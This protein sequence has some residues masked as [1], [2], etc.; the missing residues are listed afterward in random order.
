MKIELPQG[1]TLSLDMPDGTRYKGAGGYAEVDNP[2]HLELVRNRSALRVMGTLYT[3][4]PAA[5]SVEC[6]SCH[7]QQYAAMADRPCPKCGT[8]FASLEVHVC[9]DCLV[10]RADFEGAGTHLEACPNCQS[11]AAP[12]PAPTKEDRND[13]N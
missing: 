9:P 10:E 7:F 5:S 8:A 6:P 3:P 1:N 2:R 12:V 13:G 11:H 4:R